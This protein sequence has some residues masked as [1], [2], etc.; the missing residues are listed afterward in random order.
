[1]ARGDHLYVSRGA[2]THHGIDCG[3]GT[4]IH[5]LE[6]ESITRSARSYFARGEAIHVKPYAAA[7]PPA[8]VIRRAES[9]LGE[10]DY[11]LV[12]NNCEHFAAWC[13]T[14]QHRSQQVNTVVAA[15]LA[16]GVLGGAMLGSAF[17]APALAAAG[18]YGV[19]KLMEQ[20]QN[21][22][23]PQL[24]Q[25]YMQSAIAQLQA[26]Y[27][28]QQQALAQVQAEMLSWERTARLALEQN[29][30]DLA[31]A[32]LEKKYPL[33]LKAR[34]LEPRLQEVRVLLQKIQQQ[35]LPLIEVPEAS[36]GLLD[37]PPGSP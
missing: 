17:A 28:E 3:D 19:S 33:K 37:L 1:M 23:D 25:Q 29:R 31:R 15:S 24:A 22:R 34:E 9:R 30:D 5:Y 35:G 20:A 6:G 12:F 2:Y 10:R 27:R 11:S 4:V 8:V 16:G 18:V 32:A 21:A 36:S 14:G 26:T 13:K 7:D